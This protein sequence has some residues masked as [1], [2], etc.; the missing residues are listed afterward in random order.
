MHLKRIMMQTA[1]L[2]EASAYDAAIR[3]GLTWR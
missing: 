3:Y 1:Q 2:A